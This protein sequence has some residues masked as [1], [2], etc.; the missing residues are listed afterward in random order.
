VTPDDRPT[1]DPTPDP[2]LRGVVRLAVAD[3][4]GRLG[5]PA[6]D[7]LVVSAEIVTWPDGGLG[8]R[9]PGMRYLQRP[10][11]GSRTVLENAGRRYAYHT[12]GRT[13]VPFLCERPG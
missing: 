10:V 2:A 1:D 12:G 5:V 7:V 11:D 13:A 6:D 4:A 8:C 3:L 9:R